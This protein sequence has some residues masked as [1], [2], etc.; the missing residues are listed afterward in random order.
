MKLRENSKLEKQTG[1]PPV[2]VFDNMSEK[3]YETDTYHVESEKGNARSKASKTE[4]MEESKCNARKI[5]DMTYPLS[6]C[7]C[8]RNNN[9]WMYTHFRKI[10]LSLALSNDITFG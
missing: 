3:D 6:M 7:V 5:I 1:R 2:N 4:R 10:R 9:V 8:G